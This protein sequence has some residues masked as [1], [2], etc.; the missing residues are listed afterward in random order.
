MALLQ[1]VLDSMSVLCCHFVASLIASYFFGGPFIL[2][3]LGHGLLGSGLTYF[4]LVG[5]I[6]SFV[7]AFVLLEDASEE[8]SSGGLSLDAMA[9]VTTGIIN[10]KTAGGHILIN[11]VLAILYLFVYAY[12]WE[13]SSVCCIVVLVLWL[14]NLAAPLILLAMLD[15]DK[16]KEMIGQPEQ[17]ETD[18]M[19]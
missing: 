13:Y 6:V 5:A 7:A 2:I 19:M 10:K 4:I 17:I 8:E 16:I 14:L 9:S 18:L 3:T 12:D 15:E 11:A 1:S